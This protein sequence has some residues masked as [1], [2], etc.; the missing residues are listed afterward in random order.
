M[1]AHTYATPA[2]SFIAL[3]DDDA[4][5]AAGFGSPEE[6]RARSEPSVRAAPLRNG[7]VSWLDDAIAA[8]LRGEVHALDA[9]PVRQPGTPMRAR[10]WDALRR[11]PAG[12]TV[13]YAE[14][15]AAAGSPTAARA[16]GSACAT[17]RVALIVPCHRVVRA[18]GSTG[19]YRYG[20]AVKEWL[21]EHERRA[22][23]RAS[24]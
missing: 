24:A 10:L 12:A 18:D 20:A 13:S 4:V 2:G 1:I 7:R 6:L 3:V 15:A 23:A 16:A 11:V 17:N 8:Y 14:L 5:V 19:G 9:V 22:T 21:L